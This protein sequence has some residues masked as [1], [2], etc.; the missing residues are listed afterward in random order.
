M[1]YVFYDLHPA[2]VN[3]KKINEDA[4]SSIAHQSREVEWPTKLSKVGKKTNFANAHAH[5]KNQRLLVIPF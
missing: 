2:L 3:V 5:L 4:N 1:L